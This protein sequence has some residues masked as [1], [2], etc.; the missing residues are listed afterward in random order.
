[1]SL[2]WNM[3]SGSCQRQWNSV[4][5]MY[6]A[7]GSITLQNGNEVVLSSCGRFAVNSLPER[8]ELHNVEEGGAVLMVGKG[9]ID[10]CMKR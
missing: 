10:Q 6:N 3:R 9:L 1:M 8:N 5:G 2:C 7:Y 4:L